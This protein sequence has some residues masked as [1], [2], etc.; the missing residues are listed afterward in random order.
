MSS[1]R[2]SEIFNEIKRG[3]RDSSTFEAGRNEQALEFVKA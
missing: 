3:E 1:L 2:S